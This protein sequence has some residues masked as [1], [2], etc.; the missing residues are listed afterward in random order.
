MSYAVPL[1]DI[2]GAFLVVPDM[3]SDE[4]G[5]FCATGNTKTIPGPVPAFSRDCMSRSAAG[6]LRGLH[7]RPGAGEAKLVRCSAGRIFDVIVDLRAGSPT[8]L[9][10]A[11]V[12]L[13]GAT[14]HSVYIPAGCAHGFQALLD[15]TDVIYRID[16][17]YLP[18]AELVLAWDDPELAIPWPLQPVLSGKDRQGLPVAV[19]AQQL[20]VQSGHVIS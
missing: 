5:F 19:I 4:R 14:Q 20:L 9:Q 10:W 7:V 6:V 2:D 13:D 17:D 12:I 11:S 18:G 1:D 8:W 16:A 15:D 3:H